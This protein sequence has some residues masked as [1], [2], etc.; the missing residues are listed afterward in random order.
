MIKNLKSQIESQKTKVE[1]LREEIKTQ[2]DKMNG[3]ISLS[4][5]EFKKIMNLHSNL[6]HEKSKEQDKLSNLR[7]A[8][9]YLLRAN[10]ADHIDAFNPEMSC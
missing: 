4:D 7:Q 8:L 3:D 5:D 1:S 6:T 2:S 9:Y 10:G